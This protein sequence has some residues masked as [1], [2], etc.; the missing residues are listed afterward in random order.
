MAITYYTYVILTPGQS[1]EVQIIFADQRSG[2]RPPE[3]DDYVWDTDLRLPKAIAQYF[4]ITG[5][6][7]VFLACQA[8]PGAGLGC[9]SSVAVA[10][11]KALAFWCGLDLGPAEVAELACHIEIDAVKMRVGKQDQYASAFGGLNCIHFSSKGVMVEPLQMPH[12]ARESLEQNLMLFFAG[13]SL[14]STS[15]LHRQE[16]AS[17]EDERETIAR[18]DAIKALGSEMC[19]VLSQGDLTAFGELLHE[20]WMNKRGLTHGISN[21]FL[22]RCYQAALDNG[23]IGGKVTGAGGGGHMIFLCPE[24]RQPAVSDALTALGLQRRSFRID[25]DGVQVM[26]VSPRPG[27]PMLRMPSARR[28]A[29]RLHIRVG[30]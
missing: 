24:A 10:M 8:P 29:E 13:S 9:S 4:H 23:A 30:G 5:G 2:R 16:R 27:A 14:Q 12:E 26:E 18:L 7:T 20:S 6:L 25:A 11:I 21:E 3:C 28:A 1:D 22:D 15:I 19:A 17:R